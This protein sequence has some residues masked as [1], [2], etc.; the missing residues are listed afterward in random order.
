MTLK[1]HVCLV[2]L[3]TIYPMQKLGKQKKEI[4]KMAKIAL[5]SL[6]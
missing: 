5:H 6:L 1:N 3:Y 2:A 4:N